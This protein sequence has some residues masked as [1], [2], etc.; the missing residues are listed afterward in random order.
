MPIQQETVDDAVDDLYTLTLASGVKSFPPLRENSITEL[1]ILLLVKMIMTG[2]FGWNTTG[3][4]DLPQGS[5]IAAP[6]DSTFWVIPVL[7]IVLGVNRDKF[8]RLNIILLI[9]IK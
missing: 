8:L 5:F 6:I 7:D 1:N 4:L 9:Q 2:M 3:G